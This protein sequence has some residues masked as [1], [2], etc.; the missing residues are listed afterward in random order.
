MRFI[1]KTGMMPQFTKPSASTLF[2]AGYRGSQAVGYL[3][4]SPG[5]LQSDGM[6]SMS[7][8][9]SQADPTDIIPSLWISLEILGNLI[10]LARHTDANS[11]KRH[12]YLDWAAGVV[13]KCGGYAL[14]SPQS[15][16]QVAIRSAQIVHFHFSTQR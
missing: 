14:R 10:Y 12:E 11:A 6:V 4:I 3:N 7:S 5:I 13:E 8:G 1:H 16:F 9:E 2:S 15:L